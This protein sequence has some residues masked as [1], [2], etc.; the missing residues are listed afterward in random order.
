MTG[1]TT[2]IDSKRQVKKD[3]FAHM[4]IVQIQI[5]LLTAQ[6]YQCL[7]PPLIHSAESSDPVSGHSLSSLMANKK[8]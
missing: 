2:D 4:Q 1:P 5:V 3:V 8:M 7:R 6:L